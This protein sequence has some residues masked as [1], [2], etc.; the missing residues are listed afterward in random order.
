M[1]NTKIENLG[2]LTSPISTDIIP[3]VDDP[4]VTPITKK[5]T[6]ANLLA[7]SH[8]QPQSDITNLTTDL[9]LKA[10]LISP[11]F[12]TPALG[13]PASGVLTNATGLPATTGLTATGT[14]DATTFLRG[15][16]TWAVVDA[17]PLTTEGDVYIYTGSANA[18]LARGAADQVLTVNAGGTAIAWA[19][20]A[21]GGSTITHAFTNSTTTTYVGT[22]T[23]G[24]G[25]DVGTTV[26]TEASGVGEREIYI[27]KIDANNE[28]VFT[29][30]HKN[31]AAVEVQIA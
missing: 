27:K 15:D 21:G 22:A 16:D 4:A 7:V 10:P 20:P 24:T 25:I 28:G 17:S 14:K 9:A 23:A 1:A 31:G 26:A 5:V 6:I 29:V 2:E 19:D 18:R 3:I 8:T 11:T 12:V 13:T 30:I